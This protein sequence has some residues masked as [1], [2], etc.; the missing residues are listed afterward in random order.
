MDRN[1]HPLT[2][3]DLEE[4]EEKR[5]QTRSRSIKTF[6]L[7]LCA[8]VVVMGAG[9]TYLNAVFVGKDDF[10]AYQK[11]MIEQQKVL[12]GEN[13]E[14]IALAI[15]SSL[16]PLV[17]DI[18]S[19]NR[20][21]SG[22]KTEIGTFRRQLDE[23]LFT[24]GSDKFLSSSKFLDFKE[25][26]F[27]KNQEVSLDLSRARNELDNLIDES[28]KR[29]SQTLDGWTGADQRGY[30]RGQVSSEKTLSDTIQDLRLRLATLEQKKK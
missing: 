6:Y 2:S 10:L 7:V 1:D 4:F 3:G 23:I 30:V 13:A 15:T 16:Q 9:F 21:F 19:M 20:E 27:E 11:V 26:L 22:I 17:D 5:S 28:K 8:L 24:F 29:S 12:Q 18:S 25:K 14:S